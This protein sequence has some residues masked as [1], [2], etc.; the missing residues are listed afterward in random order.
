MNENVFVT[1]TIGAFEGREVALVNISGAFLHTDV[2]PVDDTV[3]ILLKGV[4]AEL[5]VNVDPKLYTK[6]VTHDNKGDTMLDVEMKKALYG[7]LKSA[8]L[9][10]KNLLSD[11]W[12]ARAS[13]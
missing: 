8:L 4:L 10:Y 12:N 2:D 9:F 5:M 7:M 1:S 6:Y 13:S 3:H 11:I